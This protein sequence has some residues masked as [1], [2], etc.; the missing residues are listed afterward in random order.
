MGRRVNGRF[1]ECVVGLGRA[2]EER[3]GMEREGKRRKGKERKR[4]GMKREDVEKLGW[5]PA[6]SSDLLPCQPHD[7]IINY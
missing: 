5:F 7:L 1:Y 4:K 2:K 6:S 3:E